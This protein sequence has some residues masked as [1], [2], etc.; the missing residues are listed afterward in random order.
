MKPM[1]AVT[2]ASGGIGRALVPELLKNYSP[3]LLFRKRSELSERFQA[4]GCEVVLGNLEDSAALR[5]L[6]KG[7]EFVFHCAA[8]VIGFSASDFLKVNVEGTRNLAEAAAA[9]QCRRFIHLSSIAVYL[10][11][12]PQGGSYTEDIALSETAIK[13]NYGRSKLLSERVIVP[14]LRES[15]TDYTILRP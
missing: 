10:G 3:R 15:A 13:D 11:T 9:N 4:G 12:E 2:G 8:K 1:A 6:T 7:C 14:I 5:S